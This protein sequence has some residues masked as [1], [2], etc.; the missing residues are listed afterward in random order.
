M[1]GDRLKS[2]PAPDFTGMDK[3]EPPRN[4]GGSYHFLPWFG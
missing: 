2:M 4:I 1:T 3:K